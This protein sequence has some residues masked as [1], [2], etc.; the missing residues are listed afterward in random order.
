[1]RKITI[2]LSGLRLGLRPDVNQ[3][4]SAILQSFTPDYKS[5]RVNRGHLLDTKEENLNCN[6]PFE[7]L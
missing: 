2:F 6:P 5:T 1:M 7:T 4:G 3:Y